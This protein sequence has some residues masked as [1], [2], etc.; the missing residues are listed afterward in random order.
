MK[1]FIN[2]DDFGISDSVNQ[3][4]VQC[5][6]ENRINRTTIMVNMP[7]AENA[8]KLAIENG[9]LDKV[10]LHIN[11][12]EGP[13]L[14]EECRKCCPC[15]EN[16]ILRGTFHISPIDRIYTSKEIR[17]A[18]RAETEAQIKKFLEMGF[19]LMHADS[20]QYTHTYLSIAGVI[21]ELIV[22]YGFTS[23]RIS[24]N[25]PTRNICPP[26]CIYKYFYNKIIGRLKVNG[27]RIYTTRYFGDVSNF[28]TFIKN[29]SL[30]RD[31]EIM[32]HPRYDENGNLLDWDQ[33]FPSR[34]FFRAYGFEPEKHQGKIKLLI[35]YL[36]WHIG[37]ATTSLVNFL[38]SIDYE[39]YDVDIL[40]YQYDGQGKDL[41]PKEVNILEQAMMHE[42]FSIKN[43]L[44][45]A[46]DLLYAI[47]KIRSMYFLKIRNRKLKSIQIMAK[48][49]CRYS[50]RFDKE[51]D[52]ALSYELTWPF[53][54]MMKFVN[55]KR[56]IVIFHNDYDEIGYDFKEDKKYFSVADKLLFVS[57]DCMEKF[58]AGH[59]EIN[60]KCAFMPN[61]LSAKTINALKQEK[62]D[63]PFEYNPEMLTLLSVSRIDFRTKAL[64]RGIEVF[65]RLRANGL[66][67]KIR[68]LI[69]GKGHDLENLKRLISEN[70]LADK[71]FCI[72]LKKN[73]IAYMKHCDALFL[74]SKNEGRPVVVTEA[75]IA[76]LVPLV[77][78]YA[79]AGEQIENHVDGLIF[80]NDIESIY[81][82]IK[83]I[84]L[85]RKIL[86]NLKQTLSERKYDNEN[87][88]T[89]FEKTLENLL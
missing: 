27:E 39:K 38:Q 88:I 57:T 51:Y 68:W 10:G 62:A 34:E 49:G 72:G 1:Y 53:Y 47:S 36:P 71:I 45:K 58:R 70:N 29:H 21:N 32:T 8:R 85:D 82:G 59:P 63:M 74:P 37:G 4:I 76:G 40:F 48:Q 22:K 25:I 33:P 9:F 20:H 43:I 60:G 30:L 23:L 17:N 44:R 14:S 67:D 5:F 42:S 52:I 83:S 79:A 31:I 18:V 19:T 12:V 50:R 11:L 77:A 26:Y 13:A 15:V 46:F 56:K 73:P 81:T 78:R 35:T 66:A 7:E 86:T 80:E 54:Y 6:K 3:A 64:D 61:L 28:K 69:I 89:Y 16:G 55:A 41:I 75:Q 2:A 65:K 84:V 87:D 24:R